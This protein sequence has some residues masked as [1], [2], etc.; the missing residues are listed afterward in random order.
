MD[1][2]TK[3][4]GQG[5]EGGGDGAEKGGEER[6]RDG[7]GGRVHAA[8]LIVSRVSSNQCERRKAARGCR[9]SGSELDHV[10]KC[11]ERGDI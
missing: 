8:N 7:E 10:D 5:G 3:S 6:E 4:R 1:K 11:G 2:D 9:I